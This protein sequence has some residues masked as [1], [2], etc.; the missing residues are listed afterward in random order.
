MIL[1]YLEEKEGKI[2]KLKV[3]EFDV[4]SHDDPPDFGVNVKCIYSHDKYEILGE[5]IKIMR[6]RNADTLESKNLRD[7]IDIMDAAYIEAVFSYRRRTKI[8]KRP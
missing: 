1:I 7:M 3:S 5:F 2:F 8:K 4:K 6:E